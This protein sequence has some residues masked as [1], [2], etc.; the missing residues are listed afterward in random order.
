VLVWNDGKYVFY[1]VIDFRDPP[2]VDFTHTFPHVGAIL[3]F[4][5]MD[6]TGN[7]RCSRKPSWWTL[8]ASW[9]PGQR[10]VSEAR[11]TFNQR[12]PGRFCTLFITSAH[13]VVV[14][15]RTRHDSHNNPT[16]TIGTLLVLQAYVQVR[17]GSDSMLKTHVQV[18][19]SMV[20]QVKSGGVIRC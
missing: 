2:G 1:V 3:I 15:S 20:R 4:E 19:D 17:A 12:E 5:R 16:G 7:R 14:D 6:L 8:G 9:V 18:S 11:R 13:F 10:E